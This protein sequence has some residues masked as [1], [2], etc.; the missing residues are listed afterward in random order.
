[1]KSIPRA[2]RLKTSRIRV[3]RI[4][5]MNVAPVY[6]G[7][8]NGMKP[9][10]MDIIDGP[11]ST[12]N[13]MMANSELD[14]SPVSSA[15]F[16]RCRDEW[17]MLPDLSI[18]CYGEVMSV[19]LVGRRPFQEMNG[20]TVILTEESETAA[21][22]L[23]LLFALNKIEVRFRT[24]RVRKPTLTSTWGSLVGTPSSRAI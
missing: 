2:H 9:P 15:A 6:Y 1:M 24:G 23:K 20:K 12:L 18:A 14:I 21:G 16:A 4:S 17:L 22:L 3:G 8:D 5:Y 13:R 19:I 10:W 7:L 11:P